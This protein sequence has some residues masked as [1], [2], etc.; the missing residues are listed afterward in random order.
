MENVKN[1]GYQESDPYVRKIKTFLWYDLETFGISPA[2]DRIAQFACIRTD[3]DFNEIGEPVVLYCKPPYDYLPSLEAIY[4]TGITPLKT[5]KTGIP[6]DEFITKI[7]DI[8]SEAGTCI[9][10]YNSTAFDDEFI[11]YSL[12]RNFIDPYKWSWDNNCSTMDVLTLVRACHDLRPDGIRW[13]VNPETGN[14]I[15]KLEEL[16]RANGIEHLNAHDALSDVRA[17]IAIARLIRER[18]PRLFNFYLKYKFKN[19][20]EKLFDTGKA[21]G[22]RKPED[23]I[24]LYQSFVFTSPHGNSAMLFPLCRDSSDRNNFYCFNLG[25]NTIGLLK[26]VKNGASSEIGRPEDIPGIVKLRIN[27]ALFISPVSILTKDEDYGRL[28]FDKVV[29]FNR[30]KK[31]E[32][33]LDEISALIGRFTKNGGE[34]KTYLDDPDYSLYEGFPSRIDEGLF[35]VIRNAPLSERLSLHLVFEN[36]KYNEMLFRYV[37]RSYPGYVK[38][39]NLERWKKR[40]KDV[41]LGCLVPEELNSKKSVYDLRAELNAQIGNPSSSERD[42]NVCAE[43]R[44]YLD[45]ICAYVGIEV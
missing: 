8:F 7:N 18:Q 35:T 19:N 17:T 4:K 22:E 41:F 12:Y 40:I 27:K 31:L 10:G 28:G 5:A 11:R 9:C 25:T 14:P 30:A 43:T 3:K 39:E 20:A 26:A 45:K 37:C 33:N 15:L 1:N 32:K 23:K 34:G 44:E 42:K 29:F 24:V 2:K 16:T 21:S 36:P 13:P 38:N 6:E